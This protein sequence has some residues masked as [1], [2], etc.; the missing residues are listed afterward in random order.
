MFIEGTRNKTPGVLGQ[1]HTG[2]AYFAKS[3][4]LP[5]VPIGIVG[6]NKRWGKVVTKIGKPIEPEGD[7]DETTAAAAYRPSVPQ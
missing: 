4:K 6:S 3:N 1:P 2:P 7:L 5:L